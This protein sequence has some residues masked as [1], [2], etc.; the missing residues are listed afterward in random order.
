MSVPLFLHASGIIIPSESAA[1]ISFLT[2]NIYGSAL[3]PR[4]NID[5]RAH[6]FSRIFSK[7]IV[8]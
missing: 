2:G 3:L 7:R 1:T 8:F 5:T 6:H 4:G